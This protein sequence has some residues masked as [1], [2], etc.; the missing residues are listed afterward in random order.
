M[1]RVTGIIATFTTLIACWGLAP[2]AKKARKPT[3]QSEPFNQANKK[4]FK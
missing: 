2:F 4:S 3:S 1:G